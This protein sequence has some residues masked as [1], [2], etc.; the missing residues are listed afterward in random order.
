[1]WSRV[2]KAEA[3]SKAL[4][5]AQNSQ[6][7]GCR[8]PPNLIALYQNL[9]APFKTKDDRSF[10]WSVC[11]AIAQIAA[12]ETKHLNVYDVYVACAIIIHRYQLTRDR[13]PPPAYG[14]SS[15]A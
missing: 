2:A 13:R 11:D 10:A 12:I 7:G 5:V 4:R 8:I 14:V 15:N 1:M 3:R 6:F 9:E